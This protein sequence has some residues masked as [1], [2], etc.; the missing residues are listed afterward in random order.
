MAFRVLGLPRLLS[1]MLFRS[2]PASSG[3]FGTLIRAAS[4]LHRN[5]RLTT[6]RASEQCELGHPSSGGL[7]KPILPR[8]PP[9]PVEAPEI[10]GSA[11]ASGAADD[12]IVVGIGTWKIARHRQFLRRNVC[13]EGAANHTRGRVCSPHL[14]VGRWMFVVR[15]FPIENIRFPLLPASGFLWPFKSKP[16]I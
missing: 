16:K 13:R 3:V 5:K 2:C 6:F 8:L 12:A 15:C 14:D 7:G 4:P 9:S 1:L 11:P 10:W